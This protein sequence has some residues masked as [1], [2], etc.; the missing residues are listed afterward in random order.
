MKYVI[1]LIVL[2]NPAWAACGAK[3]QTFMS[4]N[5]AASTKT[6]SVCYDDAN[7]YYR[8]G[9]AGE[10]PELVLQSTIADLD[11]RPWNGLGRAIWEEVG[12]ENQGYTYAVHAGFDRPWGDE[13]YEDV[14]ERNFGAVSVTRNGDIIAELECARATVDYSWDDLLWKAKENLGF[15]W[16]DRALEWVALPD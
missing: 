9:V 10:V 12:F 15:T 4:C 16:D 8:F 6:L 11:Y 1:T 3:E 2:A 13:V 14:L 7:A 5:I